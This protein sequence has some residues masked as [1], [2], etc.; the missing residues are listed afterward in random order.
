MQLRK[1]IVSNPDET[2]RSAWVFLMEYLEFAFGGAW[3]TVI[4]GYTNVVVQNLTTDRRLVA[5]RNCSPERPG[6]PEELRAAWQ[7]ARGGRPA[8]EPPKKQ[9]DYIV[10]HHLHAA[11]RHINPALVAVAFPV[12]MPTG[13]SHWGNRVTGRKR[14]RGSPSSSL[15]STADGERCRAEDLQRLNER[16][17]SVVE[18][19]LLE[20]VA[21]TKLPMQDFRRLRYDPTNGGLRLT[22]KHSERPVPVDVELK[23]LIDQWRTMSMPSQKGYLF[24]HNQASVHQ[25]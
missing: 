16:C 10:D 13:W 2:E 7:V 25:R 22:R 21:R 6:A 12:R 23:A 24:P 5:L 8:G 11:L 14:P 9:Y 17:T 19:L 3:T 20:L 18:R 15:T 4:G 1:V